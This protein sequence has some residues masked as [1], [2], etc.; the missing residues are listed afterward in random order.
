MWVNLSEVHFCLDLDH[1]KTWQGVNLSWAMLRLHRGKISFYNL[2]VLTSRT[3]GRLNCFVI[4]AL[5]KSVGGWMWSSAS[6]TL[7][8]SVPQVSGPTHST[9]HTGRFDDDCPRPLPRQYISISTAQNKPPLLTT[10]FRATPSNACCRGGESIH[11]I[12]ELWQIPCTSNHLWAKHPHRF[13]YI[14]IDE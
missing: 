3:L 11:W 12:F 13:K 8:P 10:C 14:K 7:F 2:I 1:L 6:D 4:S 9:Q 5:C